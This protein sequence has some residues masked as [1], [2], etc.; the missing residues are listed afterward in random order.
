VVCEKRDASEGGRGKIVETR[1][2]RLREL[3]PEKKYE[4]DTL[5]YQSFLTT[6]LMEELV[7]LPQTNDV[8]KEKEKNKIFWSA[9]ALL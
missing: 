5:D 6:V 1:A 7:S 9:S 4:G 2:S 8:D 3:R